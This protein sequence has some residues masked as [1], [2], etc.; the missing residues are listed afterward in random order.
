[1]K[2][3]SA[4]SFPSGPATSK[5]GH[6][7]N[8]TKQAKKKISNTDQTVKRD[9]KGRFIKGSKPTN[10]FNKNPKNIAAGGY[11]RYK[12]HGKSAIMEIFKMSVADFNSLK[13]I[14]ENDKTVLDEVLYIKF[15]S[16]M[17]GNSKDADFLFNQAF[18]D[19]PHFRDADEEYRKRYEPHDNPFH[20]LTIEELRSLLAIKK[21]N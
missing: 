13:D 2:N 9:N 5:Q 11:W 3:S 16:A 10:G 21:S 1:M 7:E 20:G 4:K 14:K 15:K 17:A 19:A 12:A 6:V 8:S 18:G